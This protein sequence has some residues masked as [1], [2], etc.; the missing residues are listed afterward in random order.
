MD[1][2]EFGELDFR[3]VA[4]GVEKGLFA[5]VGWG[6]EQVNANL[7]DL[8]LSPRLMSLKDLLELSR[9]SLRTKLD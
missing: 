2:I 4:E 9:R 5:G 6:L 1:L 8:R 7:W 3:T